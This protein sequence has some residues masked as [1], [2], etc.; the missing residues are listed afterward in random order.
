[1]LWSIE[2]QNE[3]NVASGT[4]TEKLLQ[5]RTA[6]CLVAVFTA[7]IDFTSKWKL[8]ST[9]FCRNCQLL[10]SLQVLCSGEH[11]SIIDTLD[12]WL[13]RSIRPFVGEIGERN[14]HC[15]KLLRDRNCNI[16]LV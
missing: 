4:H 12:C 14:G 1:M 16:G 9:P 13:T 15:L 5:T 11:S 6:R 10:R 7:V 8:P 2:L 3:E